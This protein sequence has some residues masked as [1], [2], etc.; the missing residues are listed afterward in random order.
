[1]TIPAIFTKI[2][3]K[4]E[5]NT[6]LDNK[7]KLIVFHILKQVFKDIPKEDLLGD[8]YDYP[9]VDNSNLDAFKSIFGDVFK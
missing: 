3:R 2:K 6:H 7:S 8:K 1:M 5:A 9:E 4:V